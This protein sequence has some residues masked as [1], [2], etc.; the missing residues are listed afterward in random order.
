MNSGAGRKSARFPGFAR[1]VSG[2]FFALNSGNCSSPVLRQFIRRN[3]Y[4]DSPSLVEV[5]ARPGEEIS[6]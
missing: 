2:P 6:D 1:L 5:D 3:F 4:L